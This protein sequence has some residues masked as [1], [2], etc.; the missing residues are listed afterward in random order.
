MKILITTD[1]YKPAV[2]GVV[3]SVLS[4]AEGLE[5]LG[6]EVRILTLSGSRHS[7]KEGRVTYIGS[8]GAGKIYPSA[9]FLITTGHKYIK[10]LEEWQPDVVH[11]QCE[12]STYFL[13]KK[14]AKDCG[15]PIVHT[16]HTIYEDY[17]SYFCPSQRVG[18]HLAAFYSRMI[19]RTADEVIVPTEKISNL[20]EGYGVET[21]VTVIPSGLRLEQFS[22]VE[23]SRISELREE[24]G[25][26]D[27][28][29][30]LVYLGRLAREKN[31]D[32]LLDL[33]KDQGDPGLKLLIVGDGPYRGKLQEE[34]DAGNITDRV[35]FTGMVDP[36][37][38]A[39]YYRLGQ[40]FV[41]AST[42][43]TQGL[44][45]IEAMACGLPLLCR[46]DKCLD[47]VVKNGIT[48]Y[49][50]RDAGDFKIKL[51][52]MLHNPD[53]AK[54]MGGRAGEAAFTGYSETGFARKVLAVYTRAVVR[55]RN[56]QL[57]RAA[58]I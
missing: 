18:K 46:Q 52:L 29:M 27:D 11:S 44:T 23:C 25:I 4:L 26:S 3:T 17:T 19:L 48:G 54:E 55:N 35:I 42:S 45:Y 20:L 15:C 8:A 37:E 34:A 2:N 51:G 36:S 53:L 1:W 7:R 14:I 33:M 47:R 49:T 41:S 56:I 21:P 31:V 5:K 32:E 57:R 43:E 30:V 50:Y 28:D 9:R 39:Y 6:H 10:E 12:F 16:Y 22:H 13:A 40:I 24:L 58:V 38:V